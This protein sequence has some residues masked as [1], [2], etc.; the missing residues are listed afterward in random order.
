MKFANWTCISS[1]VLFTALTLVPTLPAQTQTLTVLHNFTGVPDGDEPT[2]GLL[3]DAAGNLYGVTTRGGTIG[4]GSVFKVD[5]SAN[6][7]VL[8]SFAGSPDGMSPVAGLVQDAAGN[9]YGVTSYGG[10]PSNCGPLGTA[11][12][13]CGT[14][15]KLTPGGA[16]TLLHS[17]SYSF[18][19]VGRLVLDN[20]GN[21]SGVT[22]YGG[23]G[24]CGSIVNGKRVSFGCGTVFKLDASGTASVVHVFTGGTDGAFPHAGLVQDTSGNLFGTASSGGVMNCGSILHGDCGT[25]FKVDTSG[26]FSV[27]YSFQGGIAGPDGATPLSSLLLDAAGNLYGTTNVGGNAKPCATGETCGTIFQ[28]TPAGKET[29]IHS[30]GPGDGAEFPFAGLVQDAAGNFY[31]MAW[32]N[33]FKLDSTGKESV[34]YTFTPNPDSDIS[35]DLVQ[36]AEGNLYGVIPSGTSGRGAVFKLTTPPDFAV[37]AFKLTPATVNAGGPASSAVDLVAVS[38]FNDTVTLA[39][40]VSPQPAQAPQC[41]ISTGTPATLTVTTSG[42]SA[43]VNSSSGG[44]LAYALWLP[45][46]GLVGIG[47]CFGSKQRKINAILLSCVLFAGVVFQAACGGGGSSGGSRGT[48]AGAYTITVTGTS[49]AA[50]GSL[51]RSTNTTLTVQ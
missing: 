25:V 29:L 30:F 40:S 16:E 17:F 12:P 10:A 34:L 31:G 14:V 44:S 36:D 41:S 37:A 27:L 48:P 24:G 50:T 51:V 11:G 1:I 18:A 26:Q 6:E 8:Y 7:S 42:P 13:G 49:S 32:A 20:S 21:L 39:C 28:L 45:L 22:H 46:L 43:R 38:G 2:G 9:L 15:F 4:F 5:P 33:V 47:N 35:N 3:L 19:P 23:S